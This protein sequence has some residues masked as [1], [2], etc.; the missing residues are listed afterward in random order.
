MVTSSIATVMLVGNIYPLPYLSLILYWCWNITDISY[1]S[2]LTV[3]SPPNSCTGNTNLSLADLTE[4][5][6]GILLD[7]C[8]DWTLICFFWGIHRDVCSFRNY[9]IQPHRMHEQNALLLLM[10]SKYT[11]FATTFFPKVKCSAKVIHNSVW[12]SFHK[13]K[14]LWW[15]FVACSFEFQRSKCPHANSN[16]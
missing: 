5:F 11:K 6:L 10:E 16:L 4:S 13:K 3:Q 9:R 12:L 7:H 8:S 1:G 14:I 2:F 15:N